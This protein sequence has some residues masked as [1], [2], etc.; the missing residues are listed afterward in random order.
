MNND[1]IIKIMTLISEFDLFGEILWD[2][3]FNFIANCNDLFYW[4]TA[5]GEEIKETDLDLLK[6]SLLDYNDH[7]VDLYCA[8][9]R[10]MRPQHACYKYFDV[11]KRHLFNACGPNRIKDF[12]N[13]G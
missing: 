4:G 3:D 7:G 5:D 2:K 12:F 1:F 8:R 10:K 6:Q 13:P 9:K 11:N